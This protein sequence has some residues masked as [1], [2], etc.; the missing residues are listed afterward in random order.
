MSDFTEAFGEQMRGM[1]R[2][3]SDEARVKA[4]DQA[5]Q[6]LAVT[7]RP[8]PWWAAWKFGAWWD[9]KERAR[10]NVRRAMHWQ[11]AK[12]Y[13]KAAEMADERIRGMGVILA[14]DLVA[15][16]GAGKIISV[17]PN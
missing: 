8:R 9:R 10:C 13:A 16:N 14:G 15:V 7:E 1:L 2:G 11:A 6:A 5:G 3:I 12:L 4:V 17:G